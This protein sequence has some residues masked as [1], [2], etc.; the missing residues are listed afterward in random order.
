MLNARGS[1]LFSGLIDLGYRFAELLG[2]TAGQNA[3]IRV[4]DE[5]GAVIGRQHPILFL[6]RLERKPRRDEL[7]GS[8]QGSQDERKE[9]GPDQV[10]EP[11]GG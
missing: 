3:A 6:R 10:A 4:D 9:Q 7:S 5:C 1:E 11:E 8:E 2:G